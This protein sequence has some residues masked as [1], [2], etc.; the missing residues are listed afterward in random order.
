M[1]IA[2][3][4]SPNSPRSMTASSSTTI[5]AAPRSEAPPIAPSTVTGSGEP[6]ASGTLGTV[7]VGLHPRRRGHELAV[8][9]RRGRP[10]ALLV[11]LGEGRKTVGG[12]RLAPHA[13][14]RDGALDGGRLSLDLDEIIH[15]RILLEAN[16]RT[17]QLEL[18]DVSIDRL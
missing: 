15:P 4:V 16:H 6:V 13:E 9:D 1:D 3:T 2:M 18:D 10:G 11:A 5:V 7:A 17:Q 12:E 8:T 14:Q